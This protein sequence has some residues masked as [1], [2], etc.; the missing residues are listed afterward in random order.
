MVLGL[1]QVIDEGVVVDV[2]GSAAFH[3]YA[4]LVEQI[5]PLR[6]VFAGRAR[7]EAREREERHRELEDMSPGVSHRLLFAVQS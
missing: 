2:V 3:V 5:L 1:A 7:D 6:H 4:H